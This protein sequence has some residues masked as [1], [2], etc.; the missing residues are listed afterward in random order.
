[1]S[2][3]KLFDSDIATYLD[4]GLLPPPK[5]KHSEE[6]SANEPQKKRQKIY[7]LPLSC[8]KY[9]CSLSSSS[10]IYDK[11]HLRLHCGVSLQHTLQD[12][13]TKN[14]ISPQV[15]YEIIEFHRQA[16]YETIND[17]KKLQFSKK[18]RS[19]IKI[20]GKIINYKNEDHNNR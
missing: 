2:N 9:G 6:C 15:F 3:Y 20:K 17:I 18:R 1:M 4:E 5:V 14:V 12:F 8:I 11:S 7:T 13:I 16:I 10:L 19:P